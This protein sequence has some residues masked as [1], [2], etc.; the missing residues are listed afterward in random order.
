MLLTIV[1]AVVFLFNSQKNQPVFVAATRTTATTA[2]AA[3]TA[4]TSTTSAVQ[5]QHQHQQQVKARA[6]L[7]KTSSFQLEMDYQQVSF[8]LFL[9]LFGVVVVVTVAAVVVI[10]W[11][12]L[13]KKQKNEKQVSFWLFLAQNKKN[14][15]QGSFWL[16]LANKNRSAALQLLHFQVAANH[17]NGFHFSI[18]TSLPWVLWR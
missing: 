3:I 14:E 11:L 4:A 9:L 8:W 7:W 18:Q 17:G 16:F 13:A 5:Q 6:V 1:V 15:K 10:N 2:T 12:F